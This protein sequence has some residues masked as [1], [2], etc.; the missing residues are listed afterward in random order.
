LTNSCSECGG[1]RY[2][3]GNYCKRCPTEGTT[4]WTNLTQEQQAEC[5]AEKCTSENE[6]IAYNPDTNS[7]E[8]MCQSVE[9]LESTG[10]QYIDTGFKPN[11][12]TRVVMDA[13]M[14][15]DSAPSSTHCFFGCRDGNNYFEIYKAG[16][17]DQ[18]LYYFYGTSM[19][20]S[21]T[22]DYSKRHYIDYNKNNA[23][24]DNESFSY[25]YSAFQ[26]TNNLYLGADNDKGTIKSITPM[27]IYFCQIYDDDVLVRDYIPVLDTDGV[28]CL[29]D[30]VNGTF[31]YNA[32]SG[33]F[34]YPGSIP[35]VKSITTTGTYDSSTYHGNYYGAIDANG[36]LLLS[37]IGGTSTSYESIYFDVTSVPS[38]VSLVNQSYYSYSSMTA[39]M[40][41]VAI[42]SGITGSV[43]I[44]LNFGDR[45]SSSDYTFCYVTITYA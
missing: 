45:N 16:T 35:V 30:K 43:N 4:S 36:N 15:V 39:S 6:C 29:Y 33:T 40:A 8:N 24:V 19:S 26:M 13:Q 32:G 12:N 2:T 23:T 34:K 3:D 10:T 44:T 31:S 20:S 5:L 41:Y 42:F 25:S 28:A 14:L 21:W 38:G 7:C 22:V 9:Y 1:F 18:S 17:T 27:R 37:V 11:N